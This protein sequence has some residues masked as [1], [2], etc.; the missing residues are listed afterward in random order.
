M[1]PSGTVTPPT[2]SRRKLEFA[3]DHQSQRIWQKITN[4]DTSEV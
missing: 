4:L 1:E 3:Y 2:G